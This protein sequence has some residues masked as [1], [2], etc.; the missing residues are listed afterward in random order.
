MAVISSESRERIF[1]K[2]EKRGIGEVSLSFLE[3]PLHSA[4]WSIESDVTTTF[5]RKTAAIL[6]SMW[7]SLVLGCG[8]I[9]L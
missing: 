8:A 4:D 6:P 7:P 2:L 3:P 9:D 1:K 5:T